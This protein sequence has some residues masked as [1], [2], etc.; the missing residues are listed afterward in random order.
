MADVEQSSPVPSSPKKVAVPA[1]KSKAVTTTKPPKAAPAHPKVSEMV[2]GAVAG[3]NERSGSSLRA[4]KKFIAANYTVD[5]DKLAHFIRKYLKTAVLSGDLI[6]TKGKGAT[7][8]FRLPVAVKKPKTVKPKPSSEE[9]EKKKSASASTKKDNGD[10][11]KKKIKSSVEKADKVPKKKAADGEKKKEV[12]PVEKKA[13]AAVEK[14]VK[15]VTETAA[16]TVKKTG[17]VKAAPK[18]KTTKATGA[19]KPPKTPKPKKTAA[20]KTKKN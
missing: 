11:E 15:K 3:L 4:I 20:P 13:K 8:S 17:S 6:Q 10:D 5:A 12:K 9:K 19:T 18:E 1:K 16:K 14:P 2:N 7:G